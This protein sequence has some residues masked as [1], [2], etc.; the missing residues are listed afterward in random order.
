M[1]KEI[2]TYWT[3]RRQREYDDKEIVDSL[4]RH[5]R[6][7]EDWFYK[8]ARQYFD[9]KFNQVFFDK[10]RKQEIFQ[11]S[12][13]KLW[14][15]IDNRRICVM[16][17]AVSRQQKD[18]MYKP[19]TCSLTTFIM[20]IAKNENREIQRSVKEEYV[21]DLYD[22]LQSSEP[23]QA[24]FET[25]E[26][27]EEQKRRIIDDCIQQL[28]PRCV[29]VLTLFYYEQKTLDEILEI[30]KEKNVSKNGLKTAKNKCMTTLKLRVASEMSRYKLAV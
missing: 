1:I 11:A 25:E 10:D 26:S 21:A 28:S 22:N 29:E 16:D 18:G 20:A 3:S 27:M 7:M 2:K 15:E 13:L 17:D 5:D 19:M 14:M 8:K 4:Q 23:V 30:R 6:Q 24:V 9:E 12:F